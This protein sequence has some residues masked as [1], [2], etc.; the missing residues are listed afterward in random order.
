MINTGDINQRAMSER[1]LDEC[2]HLDL[3]VS[4]VEVG[5]GHILGVLR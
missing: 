5:F 1:E 4:L 3:L 2:K